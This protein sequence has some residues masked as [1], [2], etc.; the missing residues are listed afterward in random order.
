M[1]KLVVF[2]FDGV[3]TD[4]KFY[5]NNN[6]I[7][8]KC[9]NAKD[10]YSL[11]LLKRKNIKCGIITNDKIVSIK[12]A[13]HIF[14][15]LDKYSL[16]QDIPKIDI[17]SQWI[18][19]LNIKLE[20]VAYIGDDIA[21]I[22]VLKNVGFSACPKDAIKNV[23]T[24]VDY[25]CENEC[26]NGAV[27][28][29]VELIIE[30]NN[31][32]NSNINETYKYLITGGY[33]FLGINFVRYLLNNEISE[34]EILIID[35][36]SSSNSNINKYSFL[37][38]ISFIK[39][40]IGNDNFINNL[41]VKVEVICHFAA[42][43]GG[44]GSFD[45]VIYDSN[46]NSKATLLLL[47]YA[48]RINCSKFIFTSTCAV[49]G[50]LN[51][52]KHC[53]S[54]KDDVDPNT[55]YAVNK[56]S[57][58]KYLKLYSKNYGINYTIF[59][60]FNCY[61]PYQNLMNMKQGM[62]SIFLKQILSDDYPEIIVK[63]N[64]NRTRDLIYVEDVVSIIFDSISNSKFENDI[65]NLGTGVPNT[66]KTLLD[67]LMKN[68]KTKEIIIKG[69]TPGDMGKL[70]ADNTKLKKIYDNKFKF[71]TL[72]EG[73][74]RFCD[75]YID[76]VLENQVKNNGKITAVIP[77]R[78]GSQRC[79]NKNIRKF[80]NTNLLKLKIEML[81]KVKR[82]NE[83]IVSTD[84]DKMA[85]VA[86]KLN[87]K[88]H[89]RDKY[90]ASSECPNYKYWTHIAENVG[91]HNNFM[92]VNAVSP[93]IDNNTI[94][95]F[96]EK[97]DENDFKNMV[98]INKHKRFFC[99]SVTK[100]GINFDSSK[101]PNS[102][103]LIPLSE[104]TFGICIATRKQII[105]NK[106]IYGKNPIFF[107]LNSIS[108]LDI[109]ENSDFI[110]AELLYK[111][112]IMNEK[113]C[114]LIL[115]QR[116]INKLELLDCTIRDGGYLNNWN[117]TFDE[118][119][120]CYRSVSKSGYSYFEI[121]FKTN[122][123]L[124]PNKGEWCYCCEES[125]N[126][127]VNSYEGCKIAVMAKI[128]TVYIEDF[129]KAEKSNIEL[130][131]VLLARATNTANGV[132]SRYNMKDIIKARDFCEKLI[133]YGYEVSM[134]FGCGD[135]ID[136]KEIK[137]IAE[138]FHNIKLKCLYIADTYGGCNEDNIP[139]QLHKFYTEF[140]KYNSNINFG[141]HSH[142]NNNNA[143]HKA[144]IATYNGCKMIDSCIGG[145]GRGSGNLKS[146][147]LLLDLNGDNISQVIP[148]IEFYE[149][150]IISKKKYNQNIYIQSHPY[151]MIA[152]ILSLH[153]NYIMEI[154][155]NEE[156]EVKKDVELIMKIDKYTKENNKRNYDKNLL[157]TFY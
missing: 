54:E 75:H 58:E 66:V 1:I 137:M 53:Y 47:N 25:V 148:L 106:C 21:D 17:L 116:S 69:N 112:H 55:F 102:Q 88:V 109:D 111:N 103:E 19:D 4:G 156:S 80:G 94:D 84:C 70:Y 29:F 5:F 57:S 36:L 146:I 155:L 152:G 108:G 35:N 98:T 87:V 150:Y 16:G 28:E 62:V 6:N 72:E 33:G 65:F 145:L 147:E 26:G 67:N 127:V 114:N 92:M 139:K 133:K 95:K 11:K 89:K 63:G 34:E 37:K 27:R 105:K 12:N 31:T 9:Y 42:Q 46:T 136:G 123:K 117:F 73:I 115:K 86:K 110:H 50:G 52:K 96:I 39:G 23:K 125:I 61:G 68:T 59:R 134:N 51:E 120:D 32:L 143:L 60:L 153:P 77:V 74:K 79:K 10:S 91:T 113:I 13:P 132:E 83:I 41:N 128:G 78:S 44:E 81:K 141:F 2:D 99:N 130:V 122:K 104:I 14:E 100:D 90:Y 135:L 3:F 48:R 126:K 56:L 144:K 22:S 140:D 7:T 154:L 20:E 64:L 119:L 107:E 38:N 85:L 24:I 101:T 71:T 76:C 49:Y 151:Y 97:F 118:V 18:S 138:Q 15:R 8:S 142:N 131:R 82:V 121:G 93:L 124:L 30:K 43:S 129:V 45:D 149:K 40:D 157:K